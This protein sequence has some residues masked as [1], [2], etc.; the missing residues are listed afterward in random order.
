MASEESTGDMDFAK[1]AEDLV[2]KI[3]EV[4]KE[5]EEFWRE[6]AKEE[7]KLDDIHNWSGLILIISLVVCAIGYCFVVCVIGLYIRKRK[8]RNI[9]LTTRTSPTHNEY[10]NYLSEC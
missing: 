1:K 5:E 2:A 3:I 7:L 10:P 8:R 4:A 9:D 6:W